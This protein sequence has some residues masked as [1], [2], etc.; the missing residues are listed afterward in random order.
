LLSTYISARRNNSILQPNFYLK[1]L[2]YR[3]AH[4]NFTQY[5][6]TIAIT[7]FQVQLSARKIKSSQLL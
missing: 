2:F 7:S 5:F 4:C 3:V 6:T 1:L